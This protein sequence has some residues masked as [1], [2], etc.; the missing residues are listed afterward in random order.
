MTVLFN[1]DEYNNAKSSDLLPL[2]CEKCN[3][4]FYVVK[5]L[6]TQEY[7][8]HRGRCKYCSI[9]C[10]CAAAKTSVNVVC[11]CCGKDIKVNKSVYDKSINK[12]FYCSNS[13]SSIIQNKNRIV[14]K[15]TKNKI[16]ESLKQY[17]IKHYRL[18]EDTQNK[19]KHILR[20]CRV[21]GNHYFYERCISTK[22]CCSK[23]CSLYLKEHFADFMTPEAREIRSIISRKAINAQQEERRSKNEKYFCELCEGVF[24]DVKHNE[25]MFNGWD[26]DVIINDLK[27]AVLWNGKWHYEKITKNH[28]VKQVQNRDKLKIKE[29]KSCG[30]IPYVIKDMGNYNPEFVEEQFKVFMSKIERGE[31]IYE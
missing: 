7:K 31:L 14:T 15:E 20:T 10:K 19:N 30:Y 5:K 29:I 25:Q 12:R 17:N 8:Q 2:R 23:K 28:S 13:C 16:S 27:I 21:C 26:A 3:K 4:T 22:Q 1:D 11:E 6:I 24:N 18:Q 9:E